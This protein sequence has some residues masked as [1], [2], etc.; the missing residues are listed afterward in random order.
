[1]GLIVLSTVLSIILGSCLWLAIGS[2]FPLKDED[3]WPVANNIFIYAVALLI[4][5]Y[6]T[7][8]FIYSR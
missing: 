1:M 3:K 6:L 8:F 2:R 5:V 4:P 7:I